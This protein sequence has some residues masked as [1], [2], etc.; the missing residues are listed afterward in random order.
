MM[1]TEKKHVHFADYLHNTYPKDQ[2]EGVDVGQ[3]DFRIYT[4]PEHAMAVSNLNATALTVLREMD[5]IH[6]S[7]M[8]SLIEQMETGYRKYRDLLELK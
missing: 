4:V 6:P 1:T 5:Q 8:F 2:E 3:I 7:R